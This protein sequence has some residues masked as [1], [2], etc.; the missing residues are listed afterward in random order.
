MVPRDD[1]QEAQWSGGEVLVCANEFGIL[2]IDIIVTHYTML[3][4]T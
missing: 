2:Y 3:K 4:E 1:R